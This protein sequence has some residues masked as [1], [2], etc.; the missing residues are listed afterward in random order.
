M[1]A[2]GI[3]SGE[4]L[5]TQFTPSLKEGTREVQLEFE[6]DELEKL[7]TDRDYR[8]ASL[9]PD[10]VKAFRK[11]MG[12]LKDASDE[13]DLFAM[14]SLRLERLEGKRDGQWSIRLNDQWRAILTFES[15]DSRR[16]V[17]VLEL[18]DYH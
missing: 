5:Y 12:L 2:E 7:Y 14:R 11:K 17:H 3:A 9:N 18:V 16:I 8:V 4:T 6:D 13:R 15:V 1:A 10:A